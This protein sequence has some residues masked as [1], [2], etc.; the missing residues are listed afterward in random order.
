TIKKDGSITIVGTKV[1]INSGGAPG[2]GSGSS[3]EAPKTAKEAC[4][5][6]PGSKIASPSPLAPPPAQTFSPEARAL[7]KASKKATPFVSKNKAKKKEV[8]LEELYFGAYPE[9]KVDLD[10]LYFGT[11]K[12][13]NKKS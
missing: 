11:N 4:N 7:K 1:L 12:D 13:A 3:P 9:S 6:D 5:A 10:E 2:S 8:D